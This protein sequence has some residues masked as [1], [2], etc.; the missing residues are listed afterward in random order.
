SLRGAVSIARRLQDPMAELVKIEPKSLGVGQYQH[1]VDQRGLAGE[2]DLTVEGT[3]NKVGVE[4]NSASPSLLRRVS[5]LSERLARNIVAHRDAQGPFR[6]RTSLLEVSGFGPKTFEQ[7]AGFLRLRGGEHPLDRTAVHPE[8]YGLVERM[9]EELD[10]PLDRLVGDPQLVASVPFERFRSDAEGVGR[11]TLEDIRSELEQPG[12]DPRPEF[13]APAWRDDVTSLEDL[14]PGMA[15]EG[16]VSNVTNFGAFVDLGVKRD[17]LV[18]LSELADSWVEDPRQVVRVGQIVTV[19]VLEVDRERG[20]VSLSMR[21]PKAQDRGPARKA[22]GPK[23]T[24]GP[25]SASGRKA[26]S[27]PQG[28]A[29]A[30]PPRGPGTKPGAEGRGGGKP[31]LSD[32]ARKF[33]R[34]L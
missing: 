14:R 3:V 6:S 17:G 10:V 20:R 1:D 26:A 4:L 30:G 8:R 28:R 23:K 19:R 16:R 12:R 13:R 24:S 21:S 9:A 15:L 2:L 33:T 25:D 29:S 27:S 7:A 34:G 11:F 32:L 31:Q 22:S 18:H 5:G